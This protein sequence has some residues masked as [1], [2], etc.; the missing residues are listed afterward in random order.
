MGRRR[1]RRRREDRTTAQLILQ[2]GNRGQFVATTTLSDLQTVQ[3]PHLH[4]QMTKINQMNICAQF[5]YFNFDML[6]LVRD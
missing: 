1:R 4:A 5:T 6:Q 2:N 3:Q